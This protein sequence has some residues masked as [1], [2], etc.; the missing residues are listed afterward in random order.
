[1]RSSNFARM[2]ART[3]GS[4]SATR[5]ANSMSPLQRS[6]SA[7]RSRAPSLSRER[8]SSAS[9][10]SS[11]LCAASIMGAASR[12][13]SRSTPGQRSRS[14]TSMRA[15]TPACVA[16]CWAR[17]VSAA[18]RF[19]S[20]SSDARGRR[21]PKMQRAFHLAAAHGGGDRLAEPGLRRAEFLRQ[22]AADL[23]KAVIDGFQFP[24]EQSPGKLPLA[25]GEACHA[26]NHRGLRRKS[27]I[28]GLQR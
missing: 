18:S 28:I 27:A 2:R 21:R 13:P 4:R 1:M 19:A 22:T 8:S 6:S 3:S 17:C 5:A 20:T 15:A 14:T 24:R 25:A 16:I 11:S 10:S 23:E 7:S 26:A 12:V 9:A